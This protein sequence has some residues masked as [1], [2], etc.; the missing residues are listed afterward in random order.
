MFI[1]T[2]KDII[3]AIIIGGLLLAAAVVFGVPALVA[4]WKQKGR[5]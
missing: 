2:V 3:Q 5:K 1:Y 4:W